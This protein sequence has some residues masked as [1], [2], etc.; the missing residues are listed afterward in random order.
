LARK[1][2]YLKFQPK[3]GG[4]AKEN[5][6]IKKKPSVLHQNNRKDALRAFQELAK[7]HPL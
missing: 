1:L 5:S 2:A 4:I 7:P 3:V 6:T